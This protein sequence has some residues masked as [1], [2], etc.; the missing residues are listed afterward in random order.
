MRSSLIVSCFLL[1]SYRAV[2][3]F[4]A[5]ED[6]PTTSPELDPQEVD[7]GVATEGIPQNIILPESQEVLT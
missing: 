2:F 6:A 5:V 1:I 3:Q 4:S 7:A